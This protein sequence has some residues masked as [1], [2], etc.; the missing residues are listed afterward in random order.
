L[1]IQTFILLLHL[2]FCYVLL[3]NTI[4]S[5]KFPLFIS[6]HPL[7]YPIGGFLLEF[8][9]QIQFLF[10]FIN[11]LT[12]AVVFSVLYVHNRERIPAL[13]YWTIN[14]YLEAFGQLITTLVLINTGRTISTISFFL[15]I[16][17]GFLFYKGLATFFNYKTRDRLMLITIFAAC[18]LHFSVSFYT[19]SEIYTQIIGST[20]TL[21]LAIAY[22][23]LIIKEISKTQWHFKTMMVLLVLYIL[24]FLTFMVRL[25]SI[26]I[27]TS[28]SLLIDTHLEVIIPGTLLISLLI[29]MAVNFT[30]IILVQGKI[31]H[32]FHVDAKE[33]ESLL[34]QLHIVASHDSLTTLYNRYAMEK[35]INTLIQ[36][37]S[38][39]KACKALLMVDID[40]FKLF[41]DT[42]GH[43]VGDSVL[44]IVSSLLTNSLEE[45]ECVGRWGGDE[46]IVILHCPEKVR[47][48]ERAKDILNSIYE[49]NWFNV[50][51]NEEVK[52]SLSGGIICIEG[53]IS[54]KEVLTCVDYYLYEAKINGRNQI[55]GKDIVI[56]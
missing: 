38:S 41:N 28:N 4:I 26:L 15:F 16:S 53:E 13:L 11:Q 47:V 31:Q 42:Y 45:C 29:L 56:T 48:Y 36:P 7:Q 5:Y 2:L 25:F 10:G 33:K 22:I 55:R 30:I 44:K 24:F 46:F 9:P 1:A 21:A 49:Y 23:L 18:V 52:V 39:D 50:F 35:H 8:S 34:E 14:L 6:S 37:Y 19:Q 17:G 40:H 12:V 51:G 3:N 27:E 32:D 54:K 20:F 43:E